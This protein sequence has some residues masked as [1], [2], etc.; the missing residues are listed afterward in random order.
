MGTNRILG[1]W[2]SRPSWQLKNMA[3]IDRGEAESKPSPPPS[4]QKM[5]IVPPL[6]P[7]PP[8]EEVPVEVPAE[9]PL[10]EV[11]TKEEPPRR[12]GRVRKGSPS[13]AKG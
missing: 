6:P 11:E 13:D 10:E 3:K 9:V 2:Q 8:E 4:F 12:R 7:E 5:E 1:G